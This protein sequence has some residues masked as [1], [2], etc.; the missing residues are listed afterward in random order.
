MLLLVAFSLVGGLVGWTFGYLAG[1]IA[2][3][4][5][6]PTPQRQTE[7]AEAVGAAVGAHLSGHDDLMRGLSN[8]DLGQLTWAHMHGGLGARLQELGN[9][10]LVGGRLTGNRI[11][12]LHVAIVAG[13]LAREEQG[14]GTRTSR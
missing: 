11:R 8:L 6:R 13:M 5:M 12:N 4:M 14:P 3:K 9:L 7:I 10:P 1:R 2:V